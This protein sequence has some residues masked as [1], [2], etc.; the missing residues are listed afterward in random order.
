M[1][2]PT[3]WPVFATTVA[4]LRNGSSVVAWG[5]GVSTGQDYNAVAVSSTGEVALMEEDLVVP[6]PG[7]PHPKLV[8]DEHSYLLGL[9]NACRGEPC[10]TQTRLLLRRLD[11]NATPIASTAALTFPYGGLAEWSFSAGGRPLLAFSTETALSETT[12]LS[13]DPG[14]YRAARRSIRFPESLTTQEIP[15]RNVLVGAGARI[16][17][18]DTGAPLTANWAPVPDGQRLVGVLPSSGARVLAPASGAGSISV[19]A[20]VGDVSEV[21]LAPVFVSP[22]SVWLKVDNRGPDAVRTIDVWVTGAVQ[23]ISSLASGTIT[24][25][26]ALSRV[27]FHPTL[28][29]GAGFEIAIWFEQP[30]DANAFEA[31]ALTLGTDRDATNNYVTTRAPEPEPEIPRRRR[32]VWR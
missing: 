21:G 31:W 17:L 16:D 14:Q 6:D 25:H 24:R 15:G 3:A 5:E 26:G 2:V 32:M 29:Q 20:P 19:E 18:S 28:K 1:R 10:G 4:S 11:A 9:V 8:A 7:F 30:I 23:S 12:L 13:F 27:R 22:A